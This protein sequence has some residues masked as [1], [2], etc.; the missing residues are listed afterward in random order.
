VRSEIS[1]I[2]RKRGTMRA[3]GNHVCSPA[4]SVPAF[5]T[6]PRSRAT[7]QRCVAWLMT[8]P[9]PCWRGSRRADKAGARSGVQRRARAPLRSRCPRASEPRADA[10]PGYHQR[11]RGA[12]GKESSM[13]KVDDFQ[14][15]EHERKSMATANKTA[16]VDIAQQVHVGRTISNS[17]TDPPDRRP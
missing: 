6:R 14:Y 9:S 1:S 8:M 7:A 15:P 3:T 13:G 5:W 4:E 11:R 2:N 10:Q 12:Q 17:G 16:A